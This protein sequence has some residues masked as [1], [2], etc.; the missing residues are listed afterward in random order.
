LTATEGRV[1][2]LAGDRAYTVRH[3]LSAADFRGELVSLRQS[4]REAL[5]CLGYAE[6]EGFELTAD[7]LDDAAETYRLD[8]DLTTAEDTERWLSRH[9]LTVEDF[10]AWLE[11]RAWRDR[12]LPDLAAIMQDYDASDDEVETLLWPEIVFGDHLAGFSR[13]LA[14]RVA[15]QIASG[16]WPAGDTWEDEL[17][18]MERT[19]G[20]MC[21]KALSQG[22]V[23]REL[24]TQGASL[25]RVNVEMA[26]FASAEAAREAWTC[27]SCDGEPLVEV[28]E[29]AG[30][31]LSRAC[32]FLDDL[33]D[34]LRQPAWS[35]VPGQVLPPAEDR[36]GVLVCRVLEKVAPSA[37]ADEV[38]QRVEAVLLTRATD[39]VIQAHV[40]WTEEG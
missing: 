8:R 25:L 9:A 18:V 12:F 36:D 3:V 10:S 34:A 20:D 39:D 28:A 23:E 30:A 33:P 19:Y 35:A 29:R 16:A 4:V 24:S 22:H 37:A 17:A 31:P 15:T 40:K 1:L 7:T 32:L 38:R 14:A 11:R 27:V 6:D 5:A 13:A 21:A 26:T 2:F